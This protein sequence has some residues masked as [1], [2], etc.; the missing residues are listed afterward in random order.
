[1]RSLLIHRSSYCHVL[2]CGE[3]WEE[4]DMGLPWKGGVRRKEHFPAVSVWS[5]KKCV[6]V[7]FILLSSLASCLAYYFCDTCSYMF[8]F[9]NVN[10]Y[11]TYCYIWFSISLYSYNICNYCTLVLHFIIKNPLYSSIDFVDLE[12][13]L[14]FNNSVW[15]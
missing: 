1:M 2:E 10:D 13:T 4:A 3:A 7:I 6:I 8:Q 14:V 11:T 15:L 12:R 9:S 5:S